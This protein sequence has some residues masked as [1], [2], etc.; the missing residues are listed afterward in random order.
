MNS[1]ATI[2]HAKIERALTIRLLE[3]LLLHATCTESIQL[4]V[5]PIVNSRP[6]VKYI[7]TIKAM[8]NI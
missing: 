6:N 4:F 2:G 5:Q 1:T 8:K 3:N 7:V